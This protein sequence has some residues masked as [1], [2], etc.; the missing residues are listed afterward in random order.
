MIHETVFRRNW[1]LS[2]A[3]IV[4]LLMSHSSS[5]LGWN[6]MAEI[7]VTVKN[8]DLHLPETP[9]R[10]IVAFSPPNGRPRFTNAH[11]PSFP[12]FG[13]WIDKL[14]INKAYR[15]DSTSV[16]F[17]VGAQLD[18]LKPG[19]YRIQAIFVANGV[20]NH[21][22]APGNLRSE[23]LTIQ[24]EDQ[25][26]SQ[27]AIELSEVVELTPPRTKE[28][29][30]LHDVPS[31]LLT[32]FHK[33]PMSIRLGVA[34]P[35][36]FDSQSTE[37]RY[38]LIV[39]IGGFGQRR[40][41]VLG[42]ERDDRFVQVMLDGAGPHG[43]PYYVDSENN[44][45]YGQALI[46]EVI[47]FIE[48]TYQCR[49]DAK[50][51]FTTGGSTGGWVSLALQVFYPD[52][53]HGCWS[54]CPDGVDFRNF[55]LINIYSQK[56]A[57]VDDQ[58][59]ELSAMR[60]RDGS[61]HFSVRHECQLERVLGGGRWQWGGQQW[62]SWNA[63]YGPRGS[64]GPIPLWNGETGEIHKD[65]TKNW[66][67]YDL[68]RIL[69]DNWSSLGPRLAGKIHVWVG[70]SDEYFLNLA[71]A[72]LKEALEKQTAPKFDGEIIIEPGKGHTNG[73]KSS[74]IRD[75]MYERMMQN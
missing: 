22:S 71:V 65:V 33:K 25:K 19:E 47:P 42:L 30:V 37:N 49:G 75:R 56:N 46:E 3:C 69:E 18:D 8:R 27:I 41:S 51:R 73:W 7:Q 74:E 59:Q 32:E 60:N 20:I 1:T 4:V 43:D 21:P 52:F 35:T 66:L 54:S 72:R 13:Q 23:V 29:Y 63:V 58:G 70:D 53:F 50:S 57:F 67:K 17:P 28:G 24:V 61:M 9:G 16:G 39:H 26:T 62:A 5:A 15:F 36:G 31:P 6:G 44:G 48:K 38:G 45:P 10:L 68:R 34:L 12:M 40:S 14:E 2:I 64:D 11:P 55:Q